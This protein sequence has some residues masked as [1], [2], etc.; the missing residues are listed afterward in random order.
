M[1]CVGDAGGLGND[2][3]AVCRSTCKHLSWPQS[4][5]TACAGIRG[6]LAGKHS[7]VRVACIHK[8]SH[9]HLWLAACSTQPHWPAG[10]RRWP[11]VAQHGVHQLMST[12]RRMEG[13]ALYSGHPLSHQ[14]VKRSELCSEAH[15]QRVR[16]AMTIRC[17]SSKGPI[18][19]G[20]RIPRGGHSILYMWFPSDG[21]AGQRVPCQ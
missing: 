21:S 15:R 7:R 9:T 3:T 6:L 2:Q 14:L 10:C 17:A 18:C 16:G 12:Q 1:G 13:S 19:E 5:H 11:C 8:Q 20:E 4:M